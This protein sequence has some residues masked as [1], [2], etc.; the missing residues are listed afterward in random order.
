MSFKEWLALQEAKKKP[1][2]L[3]KDKTRRL[4]AKTHI[5]PSVRVTRIY[6]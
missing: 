6:T 2:K 5:Q 4:G 3:D 1:E